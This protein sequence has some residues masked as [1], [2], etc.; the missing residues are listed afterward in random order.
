MGLREAINQNSRVTITIVG[1]A[2]LLA[3][4]F[5]VMQVMAGR[6]TF[7]HKS[8]DAYFSDDDGKTFFVD[9]D[10]RVAPFDHNGKQAAR[11]SVFECCGKRF[12]GYLERYN[13]DA[14]KLKTSG[15]GTRETD[16]YGREVKK[17]GA[18][19]WTNAHDLAA[20]SKVTDV[21]CP[22]GANAAPEPV[23]P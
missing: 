4:G 22:H 17:P 21:H 19:T 8:P 9:T 3:T 6:R 10:D 18:A 15:K 13:T 5:V 14:L 2:A 16:M 7:P 23:E 12:V 1:V 20:A 11:A